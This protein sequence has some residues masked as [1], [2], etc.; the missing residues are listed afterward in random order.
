LC[1]HIINMVFPVLINYTPRMMPCILA[2]IL[3][4]RNASMQKMIAVM[5]ALHLP[6]GFITAISTTLRYFPAVKDEFG[7]IRA[8]AKLQ[9]IPLSERLESTIVPIMMSAVNTSDEIA[10]AAVV[11]G[12]ENPC[13]KTSYIR[14]RITAFDWLIMVLATVYTTATVWMGYR[15]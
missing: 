6:Q 11:R 7:H 1:P 10:A 13:K 12:I 2:G 4:V 5:R 14:L 15:I 8:A 3:L 9:N